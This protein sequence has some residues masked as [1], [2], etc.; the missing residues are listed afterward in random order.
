M[1]LARVGG[2]S[3]HK[4]ASS[5]VRFPQWLESP[6]DTAADAV[7]TH[8]LLRTSEDLER[9]FMGDIR[10]VAADNRFENL[11]LGRFLAKIASESDL[12]V[13]LALWRS[14]STEMAL[15]APLESWESS[16]RKMSRIPW[17]PACNHSYLVIRRIIEPPVSSNRP[18]PCSDALKNRYPM[19]QS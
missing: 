3:I 16:P 9:L 4:L 8:Q 6:R 14:S 18:R 17:P 5:K 7:K 1:R 19:R 12:P 10:I 15:P 11:K 2:V 13:F